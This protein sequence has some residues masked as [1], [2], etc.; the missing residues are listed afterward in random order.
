MLSGIRVVCRSG[1]FSSER[2]A[3]RGSGVLDLHPVTKPEAVRPETE[4]SLEAKLIERMKKGET[5]REA[6]EALVETGE[7]KNA[8][9]QA[10]LRLKKAL[11]E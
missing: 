11:T 10:A 6:Q 4:M 8:V 7:K 1:L 5:L 3:R 2:K 9:K